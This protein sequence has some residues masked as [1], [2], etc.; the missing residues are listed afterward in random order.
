MPPELT[1]INVTEQ[2]GQD[3]ATKGRL[4]FNS[5][6]ASTPKRSVELVGLAV[7]C[8]AAGDIVYRLRFTGGCIFNSVAGAGSLWRWLGRFFFLEEVWRM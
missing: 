5:C 4:A 2:L 3:L 1:A 6:V 7:G 8:V